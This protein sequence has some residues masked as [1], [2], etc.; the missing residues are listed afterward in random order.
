MDS[1]N[2][3]TYVRALYPCSQPK[4]YGYGFTMCP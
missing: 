1:L 2:I 3:P 4:N